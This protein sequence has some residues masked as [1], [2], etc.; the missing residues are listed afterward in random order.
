VVPTFLGR[1]PPPEIK[2]LSEILPSVP[3]II[4]KQVLKFVVEYMKGTEVTSENWQRLV[5][6][7][8]STKEEDVCALFAGLLFVLKTA[9]RDGVED[10]VFSSDLPQLAF[11]SEQTGLLLNA[12]K[13]LKAVIVQQSDEV[14]TCPR[15]DSMD[16]RIDVKITTSEMDRV[17][18]PTVLMRLVD[19]KGDIRTFEINPEQFHKLRY[20]VARVLKVRLAL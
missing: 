6:K 14:L 2:N 1:R 17:L 7:A 18:K 10:T 11:S 3:E 5:Q 8:S 12:K 9:V 20:S 4:F 19:D 15:L 13:G 16:Y